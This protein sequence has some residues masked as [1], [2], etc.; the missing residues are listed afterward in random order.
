MPKYRVCIGFVASYGVLVAVQAAL[1]AAPGR[2]RRLDGSR[3]LGLAMPAVAL[4]AGV[5]IAQLAGGADFLTDLA[6]V[7]TPLLAAGAGWARR[8]RA[9]LASSVPWRRSL[10]RCSRPEPGRRAVGRSHGSPRSAC[11]RS[12]RSRGCGRTRSEPSC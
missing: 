6:A 1:V 11:R 9:L 2:P 4:V 8:W 3:L 7:A 10:P 12:T 5:V